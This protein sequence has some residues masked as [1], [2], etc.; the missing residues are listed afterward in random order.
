MLKTI[1]LGDINGISGQKAQFYRPGM[2][3]AER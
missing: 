1:V 2:K 3:V